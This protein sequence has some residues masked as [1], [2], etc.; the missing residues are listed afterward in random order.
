M[1]ASSPPDI[2]LY[3]N[4]ALAEDLL[5]FLMGRIKCREA[6]A[7][8]ARKAIEAGKFAV[9]SVESKPAR[10]EEEW[11]RCGDVDDD[12]AGEATQQ[13]GGDVVPTGNGACE[14]GVGC[15]VR[16]LCDGACTKNGG[17][18][19]R[20]DRHGHRVSAIGP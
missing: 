14:D 2:A 13:L 6:A 12:D 5:R 11:Q 4:E 19:R 10:E 9:T 3:W 18:D 15:H 16:V 7:D 1:I 8:L 20:R 17:D